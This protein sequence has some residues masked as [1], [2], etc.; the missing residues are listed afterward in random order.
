MNDPHTLRPLL[1]ATIH[2]LFDRLSWLQR[3][4][5]L[6]PPRG[7][8]NGAHPAAAAPSLS[9]ALLTP[10][11][12]EVLRAIA[13]QR[14]RRVSPPADAAQ[15]IRTDPPQVTAGQTPCPTFLGI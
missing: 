2:H 11:Q 1:G 14:I 5:P 4:D 15:S 13:D 7:P 12:C 10:R 8:R 9:P 3:D 6:R